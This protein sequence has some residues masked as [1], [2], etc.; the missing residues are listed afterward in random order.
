MSSNLRHA[1][2]ATGIT[3]CVGQHLDEVGLADV[4]GAGAGDQ[5]TAGAKHLQGTQVEFFIA[6]EGGIE[7]A[8]GL[9]EGW[10]IENDRVKALSGR[11]EVL[12][13]VEG[14]GFDPLDIVAIQRRVLVG[15][16]ESGPGAVDSRDARATR[17]QMKSKTSLVAKNIEGFAV[18]I[19]SA[20]S[21]VLA[22]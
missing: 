1:Q 20:S 18:G 10:R 11:R 4:V 17:G 21:V 6:P 19:L 13:Q 3:G 22:L 2:S 5:D 14:V 12:E 15:D 7:V 8:L 9:S 16:F